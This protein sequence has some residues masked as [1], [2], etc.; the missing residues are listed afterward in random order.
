MTIATAAAAAAAANN[1]KINQSAKNPKREKI[2]MNKNEIAYQYY[3]L[4]PNAN[5]NGSFYTRIKYGF[6]P[7]TAHSTHS[8]EQRS[9]AHV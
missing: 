7:G 3:C 2:V 1:N 9:A 6:F 8:F 4:M 5:C